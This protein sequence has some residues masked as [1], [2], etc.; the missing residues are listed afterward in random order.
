ML[1]FGIDLGGTKIEILALNS[2]GDE[3]YRQRIATPHSSYT[4]TVA[5]IVNLVR[6][7]EAALGELGSVGI[8]T[9]G[10]VS[11]KTG[12]I[13]NANSTCLNGRPLAADLQTAL[14]REI[15]IEN[16]ANCFA[17][18]EA[19]DGAAAGAAIVFGVILGTGVGGG[20]VVNGKVLT[21]CN[22]IGI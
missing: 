18:S 1:R 8:A 7:A 22:A 14:Q 5:A 10:A 11:L 16:D 15:R 4:D 9:P 17:L 2:S 19:T 21:G 20:I 6:G 13:K 12:L 3:V